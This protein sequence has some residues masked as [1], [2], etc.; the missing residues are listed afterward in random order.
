MT[1][2]PFGIA[3]LVIVKHQIPSQG[4][5]NWDHIAI[6]TVCVRDTKIKIEGKIS[7]NNDE[8]KKDKNDIINIIRIKG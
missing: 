5:Q 2:I 3:G 7:F 8:V 6:I 4:S 1:L